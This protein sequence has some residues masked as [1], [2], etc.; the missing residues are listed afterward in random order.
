MMID[1]NNSPLAAEQASSL[2]RLLESLEPHQFDWLA[3][4]IAGWQTSQRGKPATE[5]QRTDTASDGRL[6]LTV[7]YGSQTGNAEALAETLGQRANACGIAAK[8]VDMADYKPRQLKNE[9]FVAVITSTHGEG[10]PPDSALDLHE[11]LHGRKAPSLERLKYAVLG[12][13]DTSY[14]CYCQTGKDFDAALERRGA[15][16]L[17]ERVDCDVDYDDAAE[18]WFATLLETLQGEAGAAGLPTSSPSTAYSATAAAGYDRRRPFPAEMLD[19]LVLNGRGSHKE[20]RH[21]ELSLEGSG[22][23]YQPGDALGV[24]PQNDPRLVATV[25]ERLGLDPDAAVKAGDIDTTLAR[26]LQHHREIT[27]LTR[28]VVER[29]AE[30]SASETLKA[31]LEDHA[32]LSAW[33]AERDLLDLVEEAP[34]SGLDADTLVQALRK[35][36]ARLYSI[37]SS[38]AAVD[39]EVH[40]TVAA[41]RFE[42][43]GRRREG[44]ASTWLADRL[45]ED[46]RVPVYVEHNKHFRLPEDDEMPVIMIGPGTGIAP[47]RAFM[48]E[49]EE[50]EAGGANWL[51]FGAQRFHTDFLYQSEWLAW[52]RQGLVDRIDVA[53]SRDQAE[54]VYVQ[55]R[56][57][58]NASE[59]WRWLEKGACVYVCG[60]AEAMAPDVHEALL[61]VI[62][63]AGGKRREDATD[64]LRELTRQKRYQRDVY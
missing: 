50:R 25:I 61:D 42:A 62:V 20:T 54:K 52:R 40:L 26:A 34:A 41:V 21:I 37:A 58:E 4:F 46:E 13:G 60:D 22:L 2:N 57:R 27:L 51:F 11:F 44:V 28:P 12:L 29:W 31:L 16:R 23:S 3:G 10:D 1:P 15:T 45:A 49:R 30:F 7:L 6:S 63:E 5:A 53:F 55:Q 33:M 14:E 35:L 47:F 43:R 32:E 56:I 48:Q 9:T 17:T 59:L 19:S 38:Q 24:Y 18:A 8:V 64:Y 39:E 36:P